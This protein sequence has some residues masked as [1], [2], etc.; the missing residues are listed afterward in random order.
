MVNFW[1]EI[2]LG[3]HERAARKLNLATGGHLIYIYIYDII[4]VIYI[5]YIIYISHIYDIYII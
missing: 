2:G 5:I 1:G 3:R 4:Y